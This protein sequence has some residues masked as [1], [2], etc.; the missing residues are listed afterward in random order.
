MYSVLDERGSK[1]VSATSS[2]VHLKVILSY[3]VSTFDHCIFKR[4]SLF[5]RD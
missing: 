2:T 5:D 1:K 4:I 3:N